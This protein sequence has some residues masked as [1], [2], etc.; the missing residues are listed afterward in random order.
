MKEFA[1]SNPRWDY[2]HLNEFLEA[3]GTHMPG[4]KMTFVGL[5]NVDDRIAVIAYLHTLNSSLGI[6]APDP[7]RS[8][9]AADAAAEP[10]PAATAPTETGATTQAGQPAQAPTTGAAAAP[11]QEKTN[12]ASAGHN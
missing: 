8:P 7:S 9:A 2:D 1:Q 12:P 4:T 5:K 10:A 11:T 6:P 3:P